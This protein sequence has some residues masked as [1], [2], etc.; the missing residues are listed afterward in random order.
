[1]SVN[2]PRVLEGLTNEDIEF[3]MILQI[4]KYVNNKE[5]AN[6]DSI[7]GAA[8]PEIDD[9]RYYDLRETD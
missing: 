1:M 7:L 3:S 5:Y 8:L 4:P 9:K 6:L 2:R